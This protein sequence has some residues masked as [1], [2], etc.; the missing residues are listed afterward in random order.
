MEEKFIF[1]K[2]YTTTDN[3]DDFRYVNKDEELIQVALTEQEIIDNGISSY[4]DNSVFYIIDKN[5]FKIYNT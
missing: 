3:V 4:P 1:L 5:I 2:Q